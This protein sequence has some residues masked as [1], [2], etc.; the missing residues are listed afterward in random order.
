MFIEMTFM[1]CGHRLRELVGITLCPRA[2]KRWS[3]S[4]HICSRLLKDL[5][6]LREDEYVTTHK[7]E[8]GARIASDAVD[9]NK[10]RDKLDTC[11]NLL[12]PQEQTKGKCI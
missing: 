2:R 11:I 6:H 8:S 5:D 7:E 4:L 10:L 9:R 1:R 3:L 12:N